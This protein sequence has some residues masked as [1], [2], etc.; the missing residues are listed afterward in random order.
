MSFS[1]FMR[2]LA[3]IALGVLPAAP[4]SISTPIVGPFWG[5]VIGDFRA[6]SIA[7]QDFPPA[8]L[9]PYVAGKRAAA[10]STPG[11]AADGVGPAGPQ[12]H[13]KKT[14]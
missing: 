2:V 4:G 9:V 8:H 3:I 10:L 13:T 12:T 5:E 14:G 7:R 11:V 1:D 6:K